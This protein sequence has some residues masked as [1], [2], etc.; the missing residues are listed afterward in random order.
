MQVG[1]VVVWVGYYDCEERS[2]R[3]D[4]STLAC[5]PEKLSSN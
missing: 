2:A 3:V 4:L 1:C 5:D